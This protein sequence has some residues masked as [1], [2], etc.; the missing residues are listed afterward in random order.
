MPDSTPAHTDPA[1]Q[2]VR[3]FELQ[4]V[5]SRVEAVEKRIEDHVRV[6]DAVDEIVTDVR[7][8]IAKINTTLKIAAASLLVAAPLLSAFGA[9]IVQR[10]AAPKTPAPAV[11]QCVD[12]PDITIAST[13]ARNRSKP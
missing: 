7:L 3:Q 5:D 13:S 10:E 9:W 2:H 1:L 6:I 11:A 12:L 4:R 8:E